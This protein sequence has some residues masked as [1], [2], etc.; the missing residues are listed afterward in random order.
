ME[1]M[2]IKKDLM[3]NLTEYFETHPD[4]LPAGVFLHM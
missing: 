2:I 3:G 4:L 1:Q